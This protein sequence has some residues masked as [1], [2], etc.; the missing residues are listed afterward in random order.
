[1]KKKYPIQAAASLSGISPHVIR[2]WEQR[3]K[4]VEPSRNEKNRRFYSNRD[5]ERLQLLKQAVDRGYQIGQIAPLPHE[6]L[7]DIVF[8]TQEIIPDYNRPLKSSD[9][10]LE[11]CLAAARNSDSAGLERILF[12][13]YGALGVRQMTEEVIEPLMITVGEEW[14]SGKLRIYQEHMVSSIVR[15]FLGQII[16]TGSNEEYAPVIIIAAP[17]GQYHEFGALTASVTAIDEG[18]SVKYLSTDLPAEEISSAALHTGAEIIALSITYPPDDPILGI[19]LKKLKKLLPDGISVLAGGQAVGSYSDV[20]DHINAKQ[21][22][23]I[24]HFREH[25][26]RLRKK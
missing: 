25:L 24:L 19:E 8:D 3:Y 1:M 22:S 26:N 23:N 6:E 12:K 14:H 11:A 7:K 5:I 20:L 2:K 13:A 16:L 10:M 15:S 9:E 4:A 17:K 18:Y 21:F